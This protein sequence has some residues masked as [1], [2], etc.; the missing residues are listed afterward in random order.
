[1]RMYF[2]VQDHFPLTI[3]HPCWTNSVV[4][5]VMTCFYISLFGN[6][7]TM[8][9]YQRYL[10]DILEEGVVNQSPRQQGLLRGHFQ[11]VVQFFKNNSKPILL[12]AVADDFAPA[13]GESVF[14]Q[15]SQ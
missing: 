11:R 15:N 5:S 6:P 9:G 8:L 14:L 10:G 7:A 2:I 4:G 13:V 1:M 12:K 3:G